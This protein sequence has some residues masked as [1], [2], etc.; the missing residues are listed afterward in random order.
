MS[1]KLIIY[2]CDCYNCNWIGKNNF[3]DND[4]FYGENLPEATEEMIKSQ[5]EKEDEIKDLVD[6]INEI[7]LKNKKNKYKK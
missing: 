2:S 3:K 1:N 5:K 7:I 6:K 4:I